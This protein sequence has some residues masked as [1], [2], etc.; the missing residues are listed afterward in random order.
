MDARPRYAVSGDRKHFMAL[1]EMYVHSGASP[2]MVWGP[3]TA[4]FF[5]NL[6]DSYVR[7]PGGFRPRD[8][9]AQGVVVVCWDGF[10]LAGGPLPYDTPWGADG[11]TAAGWG[12]FVRAY[13]RRKG[14]AGKMRQLVIGRL[15]ELGYVAVIGG[16]KIGNA[17]AVESVQQFGWEPIGIQGVTIF[18]GSYCIRP[19]PEAQ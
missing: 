1:V 5:G 16:T 13:A 6:F 12:T 19:D 4:D 14:L 9:A 17:G 8:L 10:S 15:R 7:G 18:G 3:A 2:G 11:M